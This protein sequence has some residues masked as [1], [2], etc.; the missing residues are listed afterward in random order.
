[1]GTAQLGERREL[2]PQPLG[3][4]PQR[5]HQILEQRRAAHRVRPLGGA[6]DQGVGRTA[7]EKR[8]PGE[9][10]LQ[11]GAV[12]VERGAALGG[13]RLERGDLPLAVAQSHLLLLHRRRG[14]DELAPDRADLVGQSART[15]LEREL[16]LLALV[17]HA[18]DP[19]QLLFR[20]ALAARVV[21]ERRRREQRRGERR[22]RQRR[23]CALTPRH[24]AMA[25]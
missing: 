23:R 5:R 12:L 16:A 11:P 14:V 1:L 3:A 8:E 4:R 21:G 17:E 15:V 7:G 22:Y 6:P 10:R 18:L 24:G 25:R 13:A 19:I 2:A 20:I 9:R